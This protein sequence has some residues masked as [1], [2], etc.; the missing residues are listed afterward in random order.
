METVA[1]A[2]IATRRFFC[3]LGVGLLGLTACVGDEPGEPH[4]SSF[5]RAMC[6]PMK[7]QG[8]CNDSV[9]NW[10]ISGGIGMV[11][12]TGKPKCGWNAAQKKYT[13]GTSGG[14]DPGGIHPLSCEDLQ[15]IDASL[16]PKDSGPPAEGPPPPADGTPPAPDSPQPTADGQQG[17]LPKV[18]DTGPAGEALAPD[19]KLPPV[20][21]GIPPQGCC[22]SPA[23]LTFC[24]GGML[25]TVN[26]AANPQCGWNASQ[27]KYTCGTPGAA[28]PGGKFPKDCKAYSSAD[29]G[30]APDMPKPPVDMPQPP[31]DAPKPPVDMPQPPVDAPKP[32]VDMPQPPVDQS[33]PPSDMPKPPSDLPKPPSD[34]P[35][36]PSDVPKPPVD[37][38]KPPVD[39][40]KPPVD[41]PKPPVDAPK[42]PVDAP[43][44]PVDMP[45]PPVDMPK[46]P[47]DQSKLDQGGAKEGSVGDQKTTDQKET[48]LNLTDTQLS[49]TQSSDQTADLPATDQQASDLEAADQKSAD[50]QESDIM[51]A[52]QKVSADA[53]ARVPGGA[54]DG[55]NCATA[56]G[57]APGWGVLLLLLL[58]LGRRHQ[59]F[60]S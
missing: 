19:T 50:Q 17:D 35:K 12:C 29:S 6:G 43:K 46:P 31:V 13:C 23:E 48:D 37:M 3:L 1:A 51:L 14:A 47:K 54:D 45:K 58:A 16:P 8:C 52:D 44:P 56:S 38:P 18:S 30:P 59:R 20:C 57:T 28:D 22:K 41:A 40:P 27:Q 10:C 7:P 36:P 53:G 11:D 25:L 39:G 5:T 24:G 49:D 33:K 42:P 2:A 55:C 32:P 15:L 21:K 26:C 34:L 9:L 4:V 60:R